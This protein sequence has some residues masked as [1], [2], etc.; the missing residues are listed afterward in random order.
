MR[1]AR[2][3]GSESALAVCCYLL[4]I[5]R[6][7][8]GAVLALT[9][10]MGVSLAAT[11]APLMLFAG[12]RFDAGETARVVALMATVAQIGATLAGVVFGVILSYR[13]DFRLIWTICALL[14]LARLA[15]FVNL[16]WRARPRRGVRGRAART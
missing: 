13:D 14:A 10:L 9:I 3:I 6:Q 5:P 12:E 4:L 15:A 11:T 1:L 7:P 2:A 8:I 16:I